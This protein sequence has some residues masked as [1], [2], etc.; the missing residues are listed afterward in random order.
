MLAPW[1]AAASAGAW[2]RIGNRKKGMRMMRPRVSP[3]KMKRVERRLGSDVDWDGFNASERVI[4]D[5]V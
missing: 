4:L 3:N 5:T 2:T 1:R